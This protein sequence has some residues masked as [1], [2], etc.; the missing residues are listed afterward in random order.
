MA[1][2]LPSGPGQ[3]GRLLE[4]VGAAL[5]LAPPARAAF[6]AQACGADAALRKEAASL[7]AHDEA[8]HD[9]ITR[10]AIAAHAAAFLETAVDLPP[11]AATLATGQTLG[12]F[13][14]DALLGEG[15]MGEVY[16]AE[17]LGLGRPVA[18]KL[19]RAGIAS[20]AL[21]RRFG[22]EKRILAGLNDPHIARLYGGALTP[23]GRPYLV[24][25]YVEGERLDDYC[26]KRRLPLEAR[27]ALFRKV[28]AA[29]AHAHQHLVVHRD[30][31]PANIR[32][33]P[34]GEPKL[35]DFGIAKL[36][37]A[38]APTD[39]DA[40]QTVTQFGAMTPGYAS[41]EQRRGEAVTTATDIFS[42]GVVLYELLCGRSPFETKK[43]PTADTAR[44]TDGQTIVRPGGV[45]PTAEAA[46]ARGTTPGRLARRLSGDLDNIVLLAMRPDPAR[47]YPSVGQFSEDIRR[48]L[49]G[50]PVSARR[51]TL[52]YVG[53]KFVA[54][55]KALT[56]ALGLVLLTLVGGVV[57]TSWQAR[58][59]DE[60]RLQADEQRRK[61]DRRFDD[62][63]ALA[64][65]L[66][67]E[68]HDSVET[69][70]GSTPTRR[71]IVARALEYLDRLSQDADNSALRLDLADAYEKIGD[72]QGNP[73]Y[74]NLGDTNGAM[75]SYRKAESLIQPLARA[76]ASAPVAA[77]MALG[78]I[79]RAVG[80]IFDLQGRYADMIAVYRQSLDVFA[81]L[82]REKP[83]D[84]AVLDE[85]SR[86]Y[87]TLADGLQRVDNGHT[88]VVRCLEQALAYSQK[89]AAQ[90]P[91]NAK[92]RRTVGV[93]LMK[94]GRAYLP[95]EARALDY[96]TRSAAQM[97]ALADEDPDNA[98]A[99]R[100]Y[101]VALMSLSQT[102]AETGH[103]P[104]CLENR[105]KLLDI[106]EQTAAADPKNDQARFD[107]AALQNEM[108]DALVNVG[109][110]EKALDYARQSNATLDAML[111]AD[112]GNSMYR[113]NAAI[114]YNRS[115]YA[116]E[117][118]ANRESLDAPARLAHWIAARTAY[119]LAQEMFVDLK[120]KGSLRSEDGD[121]LDKLAALLAKCDEQIAL[122]RK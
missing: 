8:A 58:R 116:H 16:L 108:A 35:L 47:R 103:Y 12:E 4:I 107:L 57:A 27:L 56:A 121:E 18:L 52:R 82:N 75:A 62:V 43:R 76:G 50:Q 89:L 102:Q 14:I 111:A 105:R 120:A 117:A 109:D 1:G 29:V 54:R 17:D 87:A 115:G 21:L 59:A 60:Q 11:P 114:G 61:A 55:N 67:F 112:P 83:S 39:A 104:E 94:L 110:P 91:G 9:F 32:V 64:H 65:S 46:E 44:A 88:E 48:H 100:E 42:L 122:R 86:A 84:P 63:R 79:Y 20:R 6:L 24:M 70:A 97:K 96:G 30:L 37:D 7:L 33:T 15:G 13:R 90:S 3:A 23:E 49:E 34:E 80:D 31:K 22:E 51:E 41:P 93:L 69:L 38:D 53:A 119:A 106:R 85:L 66:M 95:N 2:E 92:Y 25:E 99:R 68:I 71:L 36:L 45:T 118:L 81:Q 19:V 28:C 101:T 77:R 5:E 113:R 10:P 40:A 72:V 98:R 73:Y 78:K 26:D 74:A